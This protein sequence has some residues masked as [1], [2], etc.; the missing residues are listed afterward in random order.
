[1]VLL[2]AW[3]MFAMGAAVPIGS[4]RIL[5]RAE[6]SAADARSSEA[7]GGRR[8]KPMPLAEASSRRLRQELQ[9]DACGRSFKPTPAASMQPPRDPAPG[10]GARPRRRGASGGVGQ[11][12]NLGAQVGQERLRAQRPARDGTNE[13]LAIDGA[14]QGPD[15]RGQPLLKARLLTSPDQGLNRAVFLFK[16]L[17]DLGADQVTEGIGGE[18][19][20]QPLKSVATD[21]EMV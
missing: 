7:A 11:G 17:G 3:S 8:S 2:G 12:R 15:G 16:G 14:A 21:V 6:R 13:L 20:E 5:R 18:I 10:S 19:A 4:R 9:A 1:M